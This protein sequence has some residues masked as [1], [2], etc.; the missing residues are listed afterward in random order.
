MRYI[1]TILPVLLVNLIFGQGT[2][3]DQ[4]QAGFAA[5][6]N[7]TTVQFSNGTV[8]TGQGTL[9]FW[10]F[11]DGTNS[12]DA[13]PSHTY[14]GP[15]TYEVCLNVVTI[16]TDQNGQPLTC[17]DVFCAPVI[18]EGGQPC[19]PNFLVEMDHQDLGNGLLNF[20][21][22][23]TF[24]NTNFIW[25]FGDGSQAYGPMA[26]HQYAQTGTY[27]VCLFGWYYNQ[28]SQDTCWVEDCEIVTVGSGDPC[29]SLQSCFQPSQLSSSSFFFNNCSSAPFGSNL[30][31]LWYFG[32]G[33][34]STE[35]APIHTYQSGGTYSVCLT[36]FWG[37]CQESTCLT[38]IAE[39]GNPCDELNAAFNPVVGGL[40]VNI[41]N[42]VIDN[43]WTYLWSFGD[44]TTGS[45]P[46]TGHQYSAP[47]VY[48]ICLTVYTW[49]PVAQ[50]TCFAENCEV[51]T[52]GGSGCDPNFAVEM[53]WTGG[54]DNVVVFTATSNLPNINFIWYFGDGSQGNGSA[55]THTYAL[56]GTYSV[57]V[58]GWYYN[59]I[60]QDTCWVEDCD[61]VTVGS[62]DPCDSLQ[63]CFQP[64]QLSFSSF[65]F[66]NCSSGPFGS[67]LQFLWYFGDGTSSTE[68][69][70][71]HTYQSGGTYSVCLTVFWGSCQESTCLTVIAEGGNPCDEL[72]AAFNPVVGGQSV[73][74]QNAVIDN[75]WTYLWSFGDGTTG[76]GP[77]T[78][79]QYN[80]PGVYEICLSV[81]TW[82]PVA[83][84]TCFAENCEVITIGGSGCDPNYAASFTYTVQ[85]NAV[86]FVA[87]I[88]TPT[89]GVIWTF[90]DGMQATEPFHTHLF[91]PPGPFEVCLSSWYWNEQTQDTCWAYTCQLVDPFNTTTAVG[92]IESDVLRL[93][94]VPTHDL[95]TID[96]LASGASVQ[97][98]SADG[99]LVT[100]AR[101]TNTLHH[102]DVSSLASGTYLLTVDQ[103]GARTHRRV[104]V[105]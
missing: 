72:N 73:N 59:Q 80:A 71:I 68:T 18:V 70:P 28:S 20:I 33:T 25:Y 26:N 19:S 102:L 95:L 13:Q 23:S 21:A 22:T 31:F 75:S 48:D 84:D 27:T 63:A 61:I 24:P 67:D 34:S 96:G 92:E 85:N 62:G 78:G 8:G 69:A 15:G 83:Q 9:F 44:G 32:D 66:N 17:Q 49:D 30:Q 10:T 11:G 60:S 99:R 94:P 101:A 57:C 76:S 82:D 3:C 35:T 89:N 36:V 100:T 55:A 45:G 46:N 5:L 77:N 6:Q 41:Q 91:E 2:L 105:E 54:A 43:S 37:S 58:S 53:N 16:L 103:E 87:N 98:F 4:V 65:F 40:G 1:T 50:D 104:V 47:G 88:D 93:Y 51:I 38:V 14:S 97:L 56:S 81:Y 90:P 39:G 74:I 64:S 79:H 86:I 7:G 29:D 42:A 12:Q 52:I